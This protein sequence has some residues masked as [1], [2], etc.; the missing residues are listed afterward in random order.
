MSEQPSP[1]TPAQP[2]AIPEDLRKQ[3]A[4]FQKSLWRI[5]IIEAVLAG[6]SGFIFSFLLV[7]AIERLDELPAL[8]RLAIL[9]AGTSLAAVFAPYWVRR[10]VF[11]HRRDEQLAR[12]IARK[13]PRLGDRLLGIVEL[14]GQQEASESLSPELRAAAMIHVANQAAK[15]N[16]ADALPISRHRLLAIAVIFGAAATIFGFSIAPKAG[17]NALK[18]WLMPL[19]DT[20]HYTFTQ[21]DTARMPDPMVVAFDEAFPFSAPLKEDSDRKPETARARYGGQAWIEAKLEEDGTYRFNFPPQK[22]QA[23]IIVE[24]GDA[25]HRVSVEPLIRPETTGF[26]ATVSLP[27]YLQLG[28]ENK[29]LRTGGLTVVEGSS[30]AI[31]GTF[32][33]ELAQ[34]SARVEPKASAEPPLAEE[35]EFL[36]AEGLEDLKE[37]PTEE[38]ADPA[39]ETLR[40]AA[41]P[42][43]Y[44]LEV[45]IAGKSITTSPIELG[46]FHAEIPLAWTDV[47]GLDGASTYTLTLET[48]PDMP[49]SCYTQ[50]IDRMVLL[51]E[52]QILEF[53]I[54][55][56]DDFGLREIGLSW[57]GEFTVPTEGEPAQGSQVFQEGSPSASSLN[58]TIIFS[59]DAYGIPP[60]RLLISAYTLDYRPGSE[61]VYSEPISVYILTKEQ[62]AELIRQRF[63]EVIGELEE[64]VRREIENLDKNERLDKTKTPEEL[65]EQESRDELAESE[66]KEAENTEKLKETT[67]KMEELFKQAANNGEIDPKTMKKMAD[68]LKDMKEMSETEMPEVEQKL[69][70][71]QEQSS[72]PEKTEKDLQDAIEKQKEIVEKMKEAIKKANQAKENFEASTFINRLKK[73]STDQATIGNVLERTFTDEEIGASFYTLGATP[74]TDNIDPALE[75]LLTELTGQQDSLT[76]D[77]R[78]IMED[79]ERFFARTQKPIHQELVEKMRASRIDERLERLNDAISQNKTFEARRLAKMWADTLKE[80]AEMLEGDKDSG[81]GGGGGGGG[82]SQEEK[83]FEFMLKVMRMVKA[84][85]NIRGQTRSLEQMLRSLKLTNRSSEP[86]GK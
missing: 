67:E 23:D 5:K 11:G 80:W 82:G 32:S 84:E 53:Q 27:D 45:S 83:D 54:R 29:A 39:D 64:A 19:S 81:G 73:A 49:P 62:E 25:R 75:R 9:I 6:I 10:W 77:I 1:S 21:F 24:A 70:E 4:A 85:Q 55:G 28:E 79:L 48:V 38:P 50:G 78:W 76:I 14:Q 44:P 52:G 36:E 15:R 58:E 59:P 42:E 12:L 30:V 3:L 8:V 56:E 37:A 34:A 7:F 43:P 72:T 17:Q 61:R 57:T 33:R 13:F 46:R 20:E 16:M 26:E 60:Q 71:A 40:L 41:M 63:D 66:A 47:K 2:N 22:A 51:P 86:P 65:Q 69:G 68:V 31:T 74:G 18:R 35:S